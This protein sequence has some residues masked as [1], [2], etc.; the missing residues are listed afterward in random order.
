MFEDIYGNARLTRAAV[1]RRHEA[2]PQ[3]Q[4]SSASKLVCSSLPLQVIVQVMAQARMMRM[5]L[6]KLHVAL[7]P[8]S[9]LSEWD[10]DLR[11]S[12]LTKHCLWHV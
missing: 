8:A 10:D 6:A 4:Q 1:A 3:Q 12:T 11:S 7:K 9:N 2:L 5:H